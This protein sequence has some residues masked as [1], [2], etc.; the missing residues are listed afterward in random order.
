MLKLGE[1]RMLED[2]LSR[3]P[4]NEVLLSVLEGRDIKKKI[5]PKGCYEPKQVIVNIQEEPWEE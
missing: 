4:K 5:K 1:I 2:L 3:D